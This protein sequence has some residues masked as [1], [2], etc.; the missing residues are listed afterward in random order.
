MNWVNLP[1]KMTGLG[2]SPGS[3]FEVGTV[4]SKRTGCVTAD[5]NVFVSMCIS[6]VLPRGITTSLT[7]HVWRTLCCPPLASYVFGVR[8]LQVGIRFRRREP[9]AV[10][11]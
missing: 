1:S 4:L 3:R 8:N 10:Q 7:E 2:Q 11:T 6:C 5:G 9:M